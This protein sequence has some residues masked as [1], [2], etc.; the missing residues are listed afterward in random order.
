MNK[1]FLAISLFCLLSSCKIS[2]VLSYFSHLK[3]QKPEVSAV[4][5]NLDTFKVNATSQYTYRSAA[6]KINDLVDTK[7]AVAFDWNNRRMF[8]KA[9]IVLQ[10]H[11]YPVDSLF[12]DAKGFD[13][14]NVAL[15]DCGTD[16]LKLKYIYD[17]LTL[18]IKLNRTYQSTEK[19]IIY[20]EYV[21][22]PYERSTSKGVAITSD[23]G[24][25]FIN[26]D[27]KQ[28][29]KPRQIWTQ[30]ETESAS[31]WFPTIDKPN[32]KCTQSMY[33]SRPS[34]MESIS[35]GE[36][37]YTII[38]NDSVETDVWRM[39]QAH[40]PYLF[41]MVVGEFSSYE[42]EWR[43]IPV[44]YFV[45]LD[46]QEYVQEIFGK[47]PQMIECFSQK[48]QYNYPWPKY[49]QVVVHDYV[50]GAM[51]NTS[52]TLHGEFLHQTS[53][54]MLDKN[55]EDVIAHELFHQWFGDLVT[56]ES[57]SHLTLNES[58][59]TYGEYIWDE[60]AYGKVEADIEHENDLQSY[61]S[62]S[63]R[64]LEPIV[65][66]YYQ[67]RDD[68][69][70]R[71][72]Y[73]KGACVLHMLRNQV[74]DSAFFKSLNYYLKTNAYKNAT[75]ADLQR[76]FETVGGR[77]LSRFFTQWYFQP[78]HPKLSLS[79]SYNDSLQIETVTIKQVQAEPSL[80]VYELPMRIDIYTPEGI[81]PFNIT[82]DRRSQKFNFKVYQKP[83]LVNVDA[84]KYLLVEKEDN[85]TLC[86]FAYQFLHA[87]LFK[88]KLEAVEAAFKDSKS[89]QAQELIVKGL[90][91]DNYYIRKYTV[92]NL[93][94]AD[95]ALMELTIP[96]LKTIA[97][98]DKNNLVRA[99]AVKKL[100]P[101]NCYSCNDIFV[102]NCDDSSIAVVSA[103]IKALAIIN[104]LEALKIAYKLEGDNTKAIA[105]VVA[106]VYADKGTPEN[107]SYFLNQ[108]TAKQGFD[109]YSL[110]GQ[111]GNY[112]YRMP[113]PIIEKGMLLLN[114]VAITDP[115]WQVRYSAYEAIKHFKSK[116]TAAQDIDRVSVINGFLD[117]IKSKEK[118]HQLIEI[119]SQDI[120]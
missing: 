120:H 80:A 70:D 67:N 108:L 99:A 104:P 41:M 115:E 84:A 52:A 11:C 18:K 92:E 114:K 88:D 79:Y 106:K 32:Q 19:Y 31:C 16:T 61:L 29:N 28:K 43:G 22:K 2:G 46:Y 96:Y 109:R 47:T 77:D 82:L 111:F 30:G 76:A 119:Y 116:Y 102:K 21:A 66:Y 95:S 38:N 1:P 73:Q 87:P 90:S 25:Y 20:I 6:P 49:A 12:L 118:N 50:S 55:N 100:S 64:K 93:N 91:C 48:L 44:K 13:I 68:M 72:T 34:Y 40:S 81:L 69:F 63:K 78:G 112:L 101:L 105:A 10:P 8:G 35:N 65:R 45:D 23:R 39:K 59:A 7:L 3:H 5:I 37:L 110:V 4:L 74:G 42:D 60:Y 36:K 83:E 14:K 56:A 51:E 113:E 117:E 62:E 75:V 54:E 86:E 85:K 97:A 107:Y 33:I 98:G 89:K 103:S 24:L 27:G 58:F 15:L 9:T 53:R 94:S 71:H 57:W 26:P 17:S